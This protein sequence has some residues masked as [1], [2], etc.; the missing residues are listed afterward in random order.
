MVDQA[1]L[2]Q[3]QQLDVADRVELMNTLWASIDADTLPV[4]PEVSAVVD[5]RVAE[6]DAAPLTGKS[7][8]QVEENLRSRLR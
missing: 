5:A 2:T 6:A 1:L 3:I 7:W 8:D 4:S